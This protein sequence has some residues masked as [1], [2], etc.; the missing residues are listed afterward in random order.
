MTGGF[1]EFVH[2]H[3]EI[4]KKLAKSGRLSKDQLELV[5]LAVPE[6]EKELKEAET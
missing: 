6:L 2:E 4:I 5:L 1:R 3:A